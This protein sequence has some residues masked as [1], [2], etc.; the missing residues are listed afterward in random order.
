MSEAL[1]Y[2]REWF[3][4]TPYSS[5][6]KPLMMARETKHI[7]VDGNGRRHSKVSQYQ[8]W[9]P[10]LEEANEAIQKNRAKKAE[11]DE[12]RRIQNNAKLILE[13]LAACHYALLSADQTI[14]SRLGS[15][16]KVRAEALKLGEEALNAVMGKNAKP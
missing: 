13:A 15:K 6:P 7:L 8:C 12:L 10:T 2:P 16:N 9:Y 11:A 3:A 4:V 5:K 1:N 14:A